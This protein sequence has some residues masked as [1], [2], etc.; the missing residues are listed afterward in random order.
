[1]ASATS[2]GLPRRLWQ[3]NRRLRVYLR[4]RAACH[5]NGGS[6]TAVTTR[7]SIASSPLHCANT[8]D[9]RSTERRAGRV[10]SGRRL[11]AYPTPH[12]TPRKPT[13]PFRLSAPQR[14]HPRSRSQEV[15]V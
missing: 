12:A 3:T 9:S 13:T 2:Q 1:M 4:R 5:P 14:S 11:L 6:S 15:S 7:V 8:P 10:L